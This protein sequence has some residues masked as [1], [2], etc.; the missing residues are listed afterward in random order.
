MDVDITKRTA[1]EHKAIRNGPMFLLMVELIAIYLNPEKNDSATFSK[2]RNQSHYGYKYH[3]WL[4]LLQNLFLILR[5][6]RFLSLL[7]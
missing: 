7:I 3:A 5:S 2:K 4:M 6:L 1:E